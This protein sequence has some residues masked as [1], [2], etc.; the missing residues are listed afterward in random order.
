MELKGSRTEA[1]LMAAVE[2]E[3]MAYTKYTLYGASARQEGYEQIGAIFDETAKNEKEH[4]E[5]WLSYLHGGDL[6]GTKGNLQDAAG[7][8]HFEWSEMYKQFAEEAKAEGF[9]E[10]ASKMEQI[11]KIEK[12]HEERYNK[13]IANLDRGT[14]FSG[15]PETVW[16]CRN[17]GHV[18]V[19]AQPPAAC[20][21]CGVA[22]SYF[23]RKATNY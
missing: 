16:V 8:E 4:A 14:V 21:V 1:N 13:L 22:R 7:G 11:A 23:E 9:L 3:S 12:S 5:I 15:T 18:F 17:C 10:I 20:P 6:S 2:G 19:G